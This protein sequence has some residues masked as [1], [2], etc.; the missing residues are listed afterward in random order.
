MKRFIKIT[1]HN[2]EEIWIIYFWFSITLFRM[3]KEKS[4]D[5]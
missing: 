3:Q 1:R 2:S 4:I 5:L